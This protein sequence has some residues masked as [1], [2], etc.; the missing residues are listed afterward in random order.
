MRSI[1][2]LTAGIALAAALLIALAL[3]AVAQSGPLAAFLQPF[4]VDIEQS[5]PVDLTLAADLGDGELVTFTA[6]I[7]VGVSLQVHVDGP[8]LITVQ[9]Q[10]EPEQAQI[11]VATATPAPI[12]GTGRL[13]IVEPVEPI[14]LAGVVIEVKEFQLGSTA[15][16]EKTSPEFVAEVQRY[17]AFQGADVLGWMNISIANSTADAVRVRP[18]GGSLVIGS[19]QVDLSRFS[20]YGDRFADDLFP[21]ASQAGDIFFA[22][23]STEWA[24]ISEGVTVRYYIDAPTDGSYDSLSVEDYQFVMELFPLTGGE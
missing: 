16:L 9:A 2:R 14:D 17:E 23:K 13:G 20:F 12:E 5:I 22:L 4:V 19:E 24:D 15:A 6:P 11:S 21:D 7:T 18:L 1:P 10:A 3:T 8:Q